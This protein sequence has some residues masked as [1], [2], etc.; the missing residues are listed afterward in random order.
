MLVKVL[1]WAHCSE[2]VDDEDETVLILRLPVVL[3][4]EVLDAV[5]PLVVDLVPV[6]QAAPASPLFKHVLDALTVVDD[7]LDVVLP[8]HP[9]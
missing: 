5:D 4:E 8:L 3:L 7:E 1:L 2:S 9:E 6:T